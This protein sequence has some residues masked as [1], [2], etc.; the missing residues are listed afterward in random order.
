MDCRSECRKRRPGK[1]SRPGSAQVGDRKPAGDPEIL[2]DSD[3]IDFP[4]FPSAGLRFPDLCPA[5]SGGQA[6]PIRPGRQERR[7][8]LFEELPGRDWACRG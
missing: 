5:V 7:Q 4:R 6:A 1:A 3:C 2:Q 8:Q